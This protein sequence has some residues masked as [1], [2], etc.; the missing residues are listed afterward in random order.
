VQFGF[1]VLA[2]SPLV[3]HLSS[4]WFVQ[5]DSMRCRHAGSQFDIPPLPIPPDPIAPP[6][7]GPAPAVP[8]GPLGTFPPHAMTKIQVHEASPTKRK[9]KFIGPV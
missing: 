1:S 3:T 4:V 8:D 7:P 2:V 9:E 5:P 6:A